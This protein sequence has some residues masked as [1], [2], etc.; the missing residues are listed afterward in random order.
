[1][2][3]TEKKLPKHLLTSSALALILI[4]SGCDNQSTSNKDTPH[5][6][7]PHKPTVEL[8]FNTA[9]VANAGVNQIVS[10]GD[11]ITLNGTQSADADH[12]LMT[13]QWAQQSGPTVELINSDTLSPSFLAPSSKE[14]LQFALVVNDGQEDSETSIVN[15]SISNRT[16]LANA[17]HTIIAK[18]GAKVALTG[19]SSIDY[20]DDKLTYQWSQVYGPAVALKD[21]S[22]ANPS[23][24][25]P[26][27]S[28][29]LVFALTVNDGI[30]E[31][32]ADTVAIKSTNT[33]PAAKIAAITG[34]IDSGDSVT[35]DGSLSSDADGDHLAYT[36]NQVLGTPVM[37]DDAHNQK[38]SFRAPKRPDHLV[39]ELTVNDGE[40][41][42]HTDSIIVS[43]KNPIKPLER[44]ANIKK[45]QIA[46][47]KDTQ[48]LTTVKHD[49]Q[50]LEVTDARAA[51]ENF[52]PAMT[53]PSPAA[54]TI[55]ATPITATAMASSDD[56]SHE[57]TDDKQED[58][59]TAH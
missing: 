12:D 6:S 35:L 3:R 57:P 21:A 43:V 33:A 52:L 42:S 7:P 48:K 44:K 32:V 10:V 31:S 40:K 49:R 11:V 25:M 18:R 58:G 16:P 1:M 8:K 51:V 23:F 53:Q 17:G 36:W 56:N 19:I 15:I 27:H 55:T 5:S 41:T 59:E 28:G 24:T 37:L 46:K 45:D 30:E 20:D 38:P 2:R 9:P 47:L 39:F 34:N 22:S 14:P 54:T 13:Y 4:A 29:Y 26:F 50:T